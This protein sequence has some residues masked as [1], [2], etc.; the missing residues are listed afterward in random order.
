MGLII[1]HE[2]YDIHDALENYLNFH[3]A[4]Q[5]KYFASDLLEKGLSPKDIKQA[6]QRAMLAAKS[7]GIEIEKHF[8]LT[9]TGRAGV[10][11][12]DCKLSSL[13]YAMLLLNAPAENP[14]VG[15][16]QVKILQKIL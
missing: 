1:Y 11:I 12:S 16:W 5:M 10:V 14:I 2:K 7:A 15:Q 8:S 9:Y 3:Y 6:I 13:G 4:S